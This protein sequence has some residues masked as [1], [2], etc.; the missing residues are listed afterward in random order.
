[1]NDI[2]QDFRH[3]RF[4]MRIWKSRPDNINIL[5]MNGHIALLNGRY[6]HA[7]A[8]FLLVY[9]LRSNYRYDSFYIGL[10]YLHLMMQNHTL[11]KC[12]L[13]AQMLAFFDDYIQ[14][15]G[16]CQESYYNLGRVY[17]QL[18]FHRHAVE[19]YTVAL[20]TPLKIHD[21]RY[22]LTPEIAFNLSQIYRKSGDHGR[23]NQLLSKFCTI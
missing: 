21:K 10:C 20:Y 9:R 8:I 3:K 2:Y 15:I 22:D 12:S 19:L 17:H 13:F 16:K 6:R 4:C 23:A 11:D 18:G 7:L 5:M 14:K 1:M